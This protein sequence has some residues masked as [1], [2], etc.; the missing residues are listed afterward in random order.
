MSPPIIPRIGWIVW[1]YYKDGRPANAGLD[2]E[3]SGFDITVTDKN[4]K[5]ITNRVTNSAQTS[6]DD[7]DALQ[8][9]VKTFLDENPQD[10][11]DDDNVKGD[12]I[13][14]EVEGLGTFEFT[15][16]PATLQTDPLEPELRHDE[17]D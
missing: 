7:G 13:T 1:V 3:T 5:N 2:L 12:T 11:T 14:V 17:E 8:F 6:G 15:A 16:P 10:E 9:F 4:G